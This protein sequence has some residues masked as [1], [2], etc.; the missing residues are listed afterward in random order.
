MFKFFKNLLSR[1]F[2]YRKVGLKQF[3]VT[4]RR[5]TLPVSRRL[6]FSSF[7]VE[8]RNIYEAARKFD[9]EYTMWTRLDVTQ[10]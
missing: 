5:Y 7:T 10:R 1:L 6:V 2:P 9:T 8:A 4:A 3:V